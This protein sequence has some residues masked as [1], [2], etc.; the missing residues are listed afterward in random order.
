MEHL[1]P[2]AADP[3]LFDNE[4]SNP[5][6]SKRILHT[7]KK[8][9][10]LTVTVDGKKRPFH[11]TEKF[12][13]AVAAPIDVTKSKVAKVGQVTNMYGNSNSGTHNTCSQQITELKSRGYVTPPFPTDEPNRFKL[14]LYTLTAAGETWLEGLSTT[15]GDDEN[16][17]DMED[18]EEEINT[19]D[20]LQHRVFAMFT[21]DAWHYAA[22]LLPDDGSPLTPAV[23]A[24]EVHDDGGKK[25]LVIGVAPGLRQIY[26]RRAKAFAVPSFKYLPILTKKCI[27]FFSYCGMC[28]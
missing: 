17:V 23:A 6:V 7:V 25:H 8:V 4:F 1:E 21:M 10:S 28:C 2:A 3:A 13:Q 27:L 15:T 19:N 9:S 24:Q 14:V 26:C 12:I 11:F 16:L 5:R 22:G 18:N 20:G